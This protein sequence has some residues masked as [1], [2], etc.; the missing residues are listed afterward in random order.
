MKEEKDLNNQKNLEPYHTNP[1]IEA[2]A[3][4]ALCYVVPVFLSLVIL[5]TEK[6]DKFVRFHALQALMLV[7]SWFAVLSMALNLRILLTIG[8]APVQV[9]NLLGFAMAVFA[10]WK[11]Y[12]NQEYKLPFIGKLAHDQIYK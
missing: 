4:S 5:Y 6:Q 2:N 8:F 9:T 12:N 7:I 11:A 3:I 1:K 10:A